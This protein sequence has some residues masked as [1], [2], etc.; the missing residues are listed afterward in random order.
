MFVG[1]QELHELRPSA[2]ECCERDRTLDDDRLLVF[3]PKPRSSNACTR[4]STARQPLPTLS[5][6]VKCLFSFS[7]GHQTSN[8]NASPTSKHIWRPPV[9]SKSSRPSK[10]R[11]KCTTNSATMNKWKKEVYVKMRLKRYKVICRAPAEA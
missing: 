3:Q 9:A 8:G 1:V 6:T 2:V 4:E 5:V 7:S 10:Q 11:S